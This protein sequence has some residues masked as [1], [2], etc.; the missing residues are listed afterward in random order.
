MLV[1]AAV[2]LQWRVPS[3]SSTRL[4]LQCTAACTTLTSSRGFCACLEARFVAREWATSSRLGD[5]CFLIQITCSV[6]RGT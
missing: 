2:P 1:G 3:A 6:V 5:W 4:A